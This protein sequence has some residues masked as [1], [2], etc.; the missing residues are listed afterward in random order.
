MRSLGPIF[1]GIV[2]AV[3]LAAIPVRAQQQQSGQQPEPDTQQGQDQNQNQENPTE[4]IPAIRSPLAGAADNGQMNTDQGQIQPDTNSVTGV[5]PIGVGAPPVTHN[6][7]QPRV[8]VAATADSNPNY[9][10]GSD[11]WA[12]WLSIYGGVDVHKISEG[13]DLYLSYTGGGMFTNGQ[14]V[15]NGIIQQLAVRDRFLFHRSTFTVYEQLAYL[16]ETSLGFA[17]SSGAGVP[18]LGGTPG[19]GSGY[20]P[21]QSILTPRGQNLTNSSALEWDYRLTPRTSFTLVGS[22]AFLRYFDTDLAN[23]GAA[24]FQAG[25]NYQLT[26][27]DTIALSYQFSAIRYSNL[28]QSINSNVVQGVYARRVTG[29]LGLRV[30]A[31][32]Q[33]ITSNF[34]ITG[35]ASTTAESSSAL[36]WTLAASINYGLKRASLSASYNHGV[37]GGSGVLV[38]AETDIVSGTISGQVA[39]TVGAGVNFGFAR[40]SGFA[41]ADLTQSQNYDY[42]F[43]GVN[44]THTMGRTMDLF[45]NYQLQ[46]QNNSVGTCTGSGCSQDVVRNQISVG[47]NF[48]RTPIPF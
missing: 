5:E 17:G 40:N 7:W 22:Y 45:A 13:S 35:S 9:G 23:Y 1:G 29:R 48:H 11:A 42:W 43:A 26:R 14:D 36:Y 25:Y 24:S 19:V 6:Y 28:G 3:M 18:S 46:Y 31:G 4:P 2:V 10:V 33:Y 30:A 47:V 32:P 37:T 39:R 21:G 8:A 34:P 12:A 16:P 44:V 27:L 20:T 15:D 41:V 38:G